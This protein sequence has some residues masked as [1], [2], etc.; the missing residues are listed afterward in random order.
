MAIYISNSIYLAAAAG[1]P[2]RPL[3]GWH[4]VFN[5]SGVS[6]NFELDFAGQGQTNVWS[7]DTYTAWTATNTDD[8][9]SGDC[10]IVFAVDSSVNYYG[11]AGHNLGSIGA[12]YQ[13]QHRNEA[14]DGWVGVTT[15][16]IVADDKAIIDYVDDA[17]PNL[18]RVR[19][20][21]SVPASQ[22][23]RIAHIKIGNI[24]QLESPVWTG[25]TPA[26][27]DTRTEKIGSKSY[28][29]QHLGSVLISQGEGFN[30]QQEHNTVNFVRSNAL[31]NFFK[32]ANQLIKLSNGPVETFFYA[33]R[34]TTN[35]LEV[36]YCGK[37]NDFSPPTNQI[38]TASGGLMQWSMS[39]DAFK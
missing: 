35:P 12:Y 33:W 16:R 7:P 10:G 1:A 13:W 9:D 34:P 21:I 39:G 2:N 26:G 27:M 17:I 30:I 19:L 31:Q 36:Q 5:L 6:P 38:G 32:H 4:S 3:I 11:I 24:L 18:G 37:T 25:V 20:F 15:F 29:G 22:S 23:V 28:A 8:E 14:N